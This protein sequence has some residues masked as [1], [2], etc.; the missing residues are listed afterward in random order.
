MA[1][2]ARSNSGSGHHEQQPTFAQ[3]RDFGDSP[4]I[5]SPEPVNLPGDAASEASPLWGVRA[6]WPHTP[7]CGDPFCGGSKGT[8]CEAGASSEHTAAAPF[9][10]GRGAV[11]REEGL[12]SF[13]GTE[14]DLR[15]QP[16]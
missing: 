14:P 8:E 5:W 1:H 7:H 2:R 12:V 11:R 15:A 9:L 10:P 6:G 4:P 13:G 3:K 16:G